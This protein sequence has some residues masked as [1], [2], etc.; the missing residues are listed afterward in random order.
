[1]IPQPLRQVQLRPV[2]TISITAIQLSIVSLPR[3]PNFLQVLHLSA[4]PPSCASS[5][6]FGGTASGMICC[7]EMSA[8]HI[9]AGCIRVLV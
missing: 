7:E 1:M 6:V 8:F 3:D 2:S 4:T 5:A 9:P